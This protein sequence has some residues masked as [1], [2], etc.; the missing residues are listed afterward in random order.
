MF[1]VTVVVLKTLECLMN[2]SK[3]VGWMMTGCSGQGFREVVTDP[4]LLGVSPTDS[5]N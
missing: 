5:E 2:G 4:L 1:E 3:R